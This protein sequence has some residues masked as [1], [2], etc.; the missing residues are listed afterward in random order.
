MNRIGDSKQLK[1]LKDPKIWSIMKSK[2]AASNLATS[3]QHMLVCSNSPKNSSST[4]PIS[5]RLRSY[6][7]S[8]VVQKKSMSHQ[9][10]NNDNKSNN[11]MRVE[12]DSFGEILVP[13]DKYYGANTARSLIHF[14]IGGPS[15]KMPVILI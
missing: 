12:R 14:N 9:S 8:L 1:S 11:N 13:K 15:E 3:R 10:N 6:A 5:R 2:R 4:T 7:T